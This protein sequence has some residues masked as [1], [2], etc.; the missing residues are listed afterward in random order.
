[1][2]KKDKKAGNKNDIKKKK[3]R[4]AVGRKVNETEAYHGRYE[5]E[6]DEEKGGYVRETAAY[7]GKYAADNSSYNHK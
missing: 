3:K 7:R 1:M 4:S 5:A 2:K 6:P